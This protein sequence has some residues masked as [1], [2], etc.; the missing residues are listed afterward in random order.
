MASKIRTEFL[1]LLGV[2]P[3]AENGADPKSYTVVIPDLEHGLRDVRLPSAAGRETYLPP[4]L[5]CVVVPA[6]AVIPGSDRKPTLTFRS[7][8]GPF[9]DQDYN[10]YALKQEKLDLVGAGGGALEAPNHPVDPDNPATQ[11]PTCNESSQGLQWIPRLALAN[12][13]G[14]G[15]TGKLDRKKFLNTDGTPKFTG[16][17]A[18]AATLPIT[19]GRFFV[20]GVFSLEGIPK[21]F[22][23]A[24]VES[25]D[26]VWRQSIYKTIVWE[27]EAD[28]GTLDLVFTSGID[29]NSDQVSLRVADG[30]KIRVANLELEQLL[31][32]G[33]H[34]AARSGSDIDYAV[35]Y[36]LCSE[37][38]KPEAMP[39]PVVNNRVGGATSP[40][41]TAALF[42]A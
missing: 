15:D 17:L 8:K 33:G 5:A 19:S 37:M 28:G 13:A 9:S 2:V 36:L 31:K 42:E 27:T 14:D 25:D 41:C 23:M 7:A 10:L 22:K 1:G 6:A 21:L 39:V 40:R 35:S 3:N 16:D 24:A 30:V 4:H 38:P 18:L 12:R 20:N 32:V 34:M 29:F 11:M 26:A